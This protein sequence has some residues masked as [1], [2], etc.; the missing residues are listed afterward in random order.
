MTLKPYDPSGRLG[1]KESPLPPPCKVGGMRAKNVSEG[2][3]LNFVVNNLKRRTY[4]GLP[5][6]I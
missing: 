6:Q 4:V 2:L 1:G 3:Q 5:L